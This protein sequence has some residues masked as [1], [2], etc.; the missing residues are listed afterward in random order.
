MSDTPRPAVGR[1]SATT[2]GE[3][4]RVAVTL[5]AE[6]GYDAVTMEDVAQAIGISRR[7]LF[8]YFAT[9]ADLVWDGIDPAVDEFRRQLA[10]APT[11]IPVFDAFTA[12]Y[13][14]A[15]APRSIELDLARTRLRIID[16]HP[17]VVPL[18]SPR[19]NANADLL[20]EFLRARVPGIGDTVQ[21]QAISQAIA[22]CCFT[23]LKFWATSTDD[24]TPDET[25]RRALRSISSLGTLGESTT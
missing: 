17:E 11:D 14:A 4:A 21:L 10:D 18:A 25:L 19:L 1:P 7:S 12:A 24:E 5:F 13:V 22:A 23:A 8:R 15:I 9:K 20:T 6:R 2:A 3:I 16:A